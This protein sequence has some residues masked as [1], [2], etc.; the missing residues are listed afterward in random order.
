MDIWYE[1]NI[2]TKLVYA[3]LLGSVIGMDREYLHVGAG[4]RTYASV[5]IGAAMFGILSLHTSA[6]ADPHRIAAQV[7]S[8][9][10]FLGAGVILRYDGKIRGLTTA[11]TLWASASVGLAISNSLYILALMEALLI[12]FI[13]R[14]PK[15][16][17]WP[18]T[19]SMRR[20]K[21]NVS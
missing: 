2:A 9:I 3:A 21:N 4:I 15:F 7:V 16:E 20:R 11:A 10:G 12:T 17:F 19:K 8:G 14:A 1:L 5:C 6:G 18:R 13:L